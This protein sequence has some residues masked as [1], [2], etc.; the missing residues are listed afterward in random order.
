MKRK[1]SPDISSA[2][3]GKKQKLSDD[4]QDISEFIKSSIIKRDGIKVLKN[5][6]GKAKIEVGRGSFQSMGQSSYPI[7]HS[8]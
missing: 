6:K 5:A 4:H 7:V 2:L 3:I 8:I 1:G